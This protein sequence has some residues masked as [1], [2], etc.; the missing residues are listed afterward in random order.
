VTGVKLGG[1][2]SGYTSLK[3]NVHENGSITASDEGEILVG[4]D[5]N[6]SLTGVAGNVMLLGGKG[7]DTI[8]LK[9][10]NTASGGAGADRF[11]IEEPVGPSSLIT[12]ADYSFSDGDIIDATEVAGLDLSR[13]E[14]HTSELQSR[15]NLVCRLLLE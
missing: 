1:E 2:A 4:G 13:S 11:V 5:G 9:N 7:D 14:E 12:I 8:T 6:Q 15:E 3:V 10:G